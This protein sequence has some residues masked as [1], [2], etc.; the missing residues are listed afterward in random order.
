MIEPEEWVTKTE[1]VA[2]AQSSPVLHKRSRVPQ[3]T[4]FHGYQSFTTRVLRK[5]FKDFDREVARAGGR[6]V[7][8]C[9]L[10]DSQHE[11]WLLLTLIWMLL[12]SSL[13]MENC[14]GLVFL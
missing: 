10:I 2:D 7:T 3:Y 12:A 14:A 1:V 9:V 11:F 6:C 4:T 8:N 5:L 13:Q